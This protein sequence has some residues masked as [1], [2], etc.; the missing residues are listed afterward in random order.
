MYDMD[1]TVTHRATCS[2][3]RRRGSARRQCGHG[4]GR[5]DLGAR[6]GVHDDEGDGRGEDGMDGRPAKRV[7]DHREPDL[8]PRLSC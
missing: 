6:H 8:W 2:P 1:H 4:R 5:R 7:H 3:R